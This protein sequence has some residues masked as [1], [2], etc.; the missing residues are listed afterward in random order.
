MNQHDLTWQ[1][2]AKMQRLE[3][4]QI[5]TI[6]TSFLVLVLGLQKN[7]AFHSLPH[8]E[9]QTYQPPWPAAMQYDRGWFSAVDQLL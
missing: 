7:T 3:M 6:P 5:Q 8:D 1:M 2:N 9:S 4:F